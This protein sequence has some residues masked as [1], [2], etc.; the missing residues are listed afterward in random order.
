MP[1][2]CSRLRNA[3]VTGVTTGGRRRKAVCDAYHSKRHGPA[4]IFFLLKGCAWSHIVPIRTAERRFCIFERAGCSPYCAR[5]RQA[6]EHFWPC[7]KCA[8]RVKLEFSENE[9]KPRAVPLR[10]STTGFYGS[11]RAYPRSDVA[12][13]HLTLTPHTSPLIVNGPGC[14]TRLCRVSTSGNSPATRRP[15]QL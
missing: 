14:E 4:L 11:P 9:S 3:A 7:A 13:P 12:P 10:L 2:C 6:I 5:S 8:P 1:P 15:H